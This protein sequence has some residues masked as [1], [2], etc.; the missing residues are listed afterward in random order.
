MFQPNKETI[1][2]FMNLRKYDHVIYN[3]ILQ[4][5]GINF[6]LFNFLI[7]S[8][9]LQNLQML[10]IQI[11]LYS[12]CINQFCS[13]PPQFAGNHWGELNSK[14]FFKID[15]NVWFVFVHVQMY[16]VYLCVILYYFFFIKKL[17]FSFWGRKWEVKL[18]YFVPFNLKSMTF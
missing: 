11:F 7:Q 18:V 2:L 1:L 16:N 5:I 6:N 13:T 8:V 9:P 3:L 14:I 4:S 12:W 15:E 17:I 10:V